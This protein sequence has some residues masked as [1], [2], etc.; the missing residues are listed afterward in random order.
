MQFVHDRQRVGHL[1]PARMLQ[2]AQQQVANVGRVESLGDLID[3]L[4][5]RGLGLFQLLWPW[6]AV[7]GNRDND[8]RAARRCR[9][10]R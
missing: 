6:P 3:R 8:V 4:L 7:V 1:G 2:I 5:P 9:L 10:R